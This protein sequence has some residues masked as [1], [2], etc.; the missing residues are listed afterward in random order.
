MQSLSNYLLD[1]NRYQNNQTKIVLSKISFKPVIENVVEKLLPIAKKRG[2]TITSQLSDLTV[3]GNEMALTQL[4]IILLDNAIK[5]SH[6]KGK[7]DLNLKKQGRRA[8]FEVEDHGVGIKATEIPYIFNRFYRADSS[9]SKT[10]IDGY[11]L[12]LSIA[13][14]IVDLHKGTISVESHFG[15]G[16]KFQVSLSLF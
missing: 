10:Q 6:P 4:G 16:T 1:L 7:I 11:G 8:L 14:S 5:Y 15:Q 12:G 2:I 3:K 13:K 9:R